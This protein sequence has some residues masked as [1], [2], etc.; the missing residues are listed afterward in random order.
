MALHLHAD[1][2]TSM[3]PHLSLVIECLNKMKQQLEDLFHF[4]RESDTATDSVDLQVE[5][6]INPIMEDDASKSLYPDVDKRSSDLDV[7]LPALAPL[8][9][10]LFDF[11]NFD[12]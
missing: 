6:A 8:E 3:D 4:S 9:V 7:E 2:C 10:P 5:D 11:N 12:D 1:S